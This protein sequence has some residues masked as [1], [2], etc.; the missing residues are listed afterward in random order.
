MSFLRSS[1][2]LRSW[3]SPVGTVGAMPPNCWPGPVGTV[4]RLDPVLRTYWSG[5]LAIFVFLGPNGTRE[6]AQ[7][8]DHSATPPQLGAKAVLVIELGRTCATIW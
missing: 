4:G 5:G 2:R 7:S 8:S 6:P 3:P 1:F